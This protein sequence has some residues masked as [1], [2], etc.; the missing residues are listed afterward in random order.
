VVDEK[1]KREVDW[2]ELV[3]EGGFMPSFI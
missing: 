1:A 2:R 3:E